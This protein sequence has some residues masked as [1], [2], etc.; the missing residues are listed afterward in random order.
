MHLIPQLISRKILVVVL[1]ALL[2]IVIIIASWYC[3]CS[4]GI[5][6]VEM[7]GRVLGI[8]GIMSRAKGN[9]VLVVVVVIGS[10]VEL[11]PF[12]C[13]SIILYLIIVIK[14]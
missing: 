4:V 10:F 3:N 6:S 12:L 9:Y 13:P 5:V 8:V 11:F 14:Q 7:N 2:I 1:S